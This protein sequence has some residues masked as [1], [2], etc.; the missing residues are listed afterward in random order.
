M[1]TASG[2]GRNRSARS[3]LAEAA[4][5]LRAQRPLETLGEA[6]GGAPAKDVPRARGV[7]RDVAALARPLGRV[8]RL[9]RPPSLQAPECLDQLEHVR[10]AAGADVVRA[11]RVRAGGRDVRRNDVAD[12]HVVA[13]LQP[14]AEDRRPAAV[15]QLAAEDR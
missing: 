15:E 7:E 13:S 12:E 1:T 9:E 11:D 3:G 6:G 8:L 14:V 2:I 5:A 4:S 10:L